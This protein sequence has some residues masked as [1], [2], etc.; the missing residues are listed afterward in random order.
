MFLLLLYFTYYVF[1]CLSCYFYFFILVIFFFST[2]IG[3]KA[4]FFGLNLGPTW[5]KNQACRAH[6]TMHSPFNQPSCAWF[7]FFFMHM[8]HLVFLSSLSLSRFFSFDFWNLDKHKKKCFLPQ[9]LKDGQDYMQLKIV[10]AW[11]WIM[12]LDAVCANDKWM[13]SI[14]LKHHLASQRTNQNLFPTCEY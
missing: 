9:A 5:P 10:S 3:L 13:S 6:H 4:H 12:R 7:S 11:Q 8:Q 14:F 2:F 1:I